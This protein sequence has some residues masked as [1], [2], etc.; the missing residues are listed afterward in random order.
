MEE[1]KGILSALADYLTHYESSKDSA[2]E[3]FM[4]EI[5]IKFEKIAESV[6]KIEGRLAAMEEK[7]GLMAVYGAAANDDIDEYGN[8]GEIEAGED[9][10]VTDDIAVPDETV[11]D[12]IMEDETVEGEIVQ[13]EIGTGEELTES[14][15]LVPDTYSEPDT[16]MDESGEYIDEEYAGEEEYEEFEEEDED[17]D[18]DEIIDSEEEEAE[19]EADEDAETGDAGADAEADA[20][21]DAGADDSPEAL[22]EESGAEEDLIPVEREKEAGG[23]SERI[24]DTVDFELLPEEITTFLTD[25]EADE[26]EG[27]NAE[28]ESGTGPTAQRQDKADGTGGTAEWFDW[29]V[30]YPAEYVDDL[31]RTMGIN[32]KIQFINELF[33]GRKFEFDMVMR[34]INSMNSFKDIIN[35][36]RDEYPL[37]DEGSETIYKFYMHIRRKFR[38]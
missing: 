20:G 17:I 6:A 36:F 32:D 23:P 15:G 22:D 33:S 5:R 13:D 18:E 7:I 21:A 27:S 3:E 11:E 29:E 24:G 10:G 38:K 35:Y 16:D 28:E 26:Q 19:A 9:E 2:C 37:W 30:D 8:D 31:V 4:N 1:K 34:E 14:D 12:E 25:D